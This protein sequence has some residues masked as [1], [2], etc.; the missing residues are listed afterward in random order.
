MYNNSVCADHPQRDCVFLSNYHE[1]SQI[2]HLHDYM[3]LLT[4]Y[5]ESEEEVLHIPFDHND[6]H[7][8]YLDEEKLK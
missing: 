2:H 3:D 5:H 6:E 4:N 7:Q 8:I 1:E